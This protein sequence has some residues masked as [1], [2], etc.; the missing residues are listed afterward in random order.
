[1]RILIVSTVFPPQ[2]S[3]VS[4]MTENLADELSQNHD[5]ELITSSIS[6]RRT[7]DFHP[8]KPY[9]VHRL[10]GVPLNPKTNLTITYPHPQ[11][12]EAIIRDF[13]PDVIHLQDPNTIS[14]ITAVSIARRL[15]IPTVVTH[16]F[17]AELI[18]KWLVPV[19]RF[20]TPLAQNPK[21]KD[22]IYRLVNLMYNRCDLVTVPNPVLIPAL[23][24]AKLKTPII[25]IPNGMDIK[26]FQKRPTDRQYL[27]Q[28]KLTHPVI[29][30]VG[31]LDV[32]KNLD[33]LLEAVAGIRTQ[34]PL[35]T[36]VLVGSGFQ[37]QKLKELTKALHL[38][39]SVRFLGRIDNKSEKLK[40]LYQEADLFVNPSVIENQSL[41]FIEAM[42]AGLPLIAFDTPLYQGFMSH[43]IHGL[44]FSPH[45]ASALTAAMQKLISEP[46]LRHRISLINRKRARRYDIGQVAKQ[47]LAAYQSLL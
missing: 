23:K 27:K 33:L 36:L 34:N 15:R 38:G 28:L 7:V 9:R 8:G 26:S 22:P 19:R 31:R 32:D 24:N 12:V 47:Y 43:S 29:L 17:T 20:S 14:S 6:S 11:K 44:L 16:H 10:S 18:L 45:S 37:E 42:A 35:S 5:V 25:S 39:H 3:G 40:S 30:F 21:L 4:T 2:L 13:K 41:S 1:M 46:K